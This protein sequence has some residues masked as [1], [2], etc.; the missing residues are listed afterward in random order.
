MIMH[1]FYIYIYLKGHDE[2]ELKPKWAAKVRVVH[3]ILKCRA[4]TN[5]NLEFE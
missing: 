4:E 1:H 2:K 5:T 3:N